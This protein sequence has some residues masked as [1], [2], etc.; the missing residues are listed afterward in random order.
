MTIRA[1]REQ[2]GLTQADVAR[3]L[4][5]SRLAYINKEHNP[6]T[7][8]VGQWKRLGAIL[9]IEPNALLMKKL[10]PCAQCDGTGLIEVEI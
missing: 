1:I 10:E 4:K 3:E 8:S 5:M 6:D 2:R 9:E 7:F